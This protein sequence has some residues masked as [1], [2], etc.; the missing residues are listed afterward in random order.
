MAKKGSVNS[1][2]MMPIERVR[3][4]RNER[5]TSFG[6]K[7]SAAIA[8]S[9]RSRVCSDTGTLPLRTRDT[10]MVPTPANSATSRMVGLVRVVLGFRI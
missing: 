10:V 1:G 8:C 3:A 7:C 4:S 9:T 2:T 5:A 6:R